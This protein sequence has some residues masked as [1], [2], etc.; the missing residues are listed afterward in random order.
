MALAGGA[1]EEEDGAGVE[2]SATEPDELASSGSWER[3]VEPEART[4]SGVMEPEAGES[5]AESEASESDVAVALQV[6]WRVGGDRIALCWDRMKLI[7]FSQEFLSS[8][9]IDCKKIRAS[10]FERWIS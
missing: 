10:L 9:D 7:L 2:V 8:E 6:E 1:D 4:E 5:G 3:V